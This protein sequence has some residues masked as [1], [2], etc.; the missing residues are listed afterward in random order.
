MTK[1]MSLKDIVACVDGTLIQNKLNQI[2]NSHIITINSICAFDEPVA[3]SICFTQEKNLSKLSILYD[4]FPASC[5]VVRKDIM[6]PTNL[7]PV[8]LIGVLDPLKAML[9]LVSH[10][11]HFP[12]VDKGIHPTACVHP[13]AFVAE[14]VSIGAFSVVGKNAKIGAR[15]VLHPHV[16]LYEGASIGTECILHSGVTVREFCTL[17]D[18]SVVQNGA[19]I[20]ADGFGYYHDPA[21]GLVAV[22]QIGTVVLATGV[23]VGA[24]SC[25]DR[26]TFGTTR[27]ETG[28]KIDNLVQIGHN[29]KIGKHSIVCGQVGIAGSC[30]I[31]DQVVLGGATKVG[32]HLHIASGVRTGGASNVRNSVTERGD[33][34]GDGPLPKAQWLRVSALTRQLPKIL[35]DLK[36]FMKNS[37]DS[38]LG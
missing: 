16:V 10:L 20:G 1:D 34:A 37:K 2:S 12:V 6:L 24:N 22:P 8:A 15:T 38:D 28:T 33:Y 18:R 31:G 21:Q 9:T 7:P 14:E 4:S 36:A 26:A 35:G 23:D 30:T 32:D 27:V 25:I 13:T 19:I 11:H 17:Q 5:I 29:N 3:G